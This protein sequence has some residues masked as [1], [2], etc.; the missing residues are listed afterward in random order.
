MAGIEVEDL[1]AVVYRNK[2]SDRMA[3]GNRVGVC[4]SYASDIKESM[5]LVASQIDITVPEI[6]VKMELSR[7]NFLQEVLISY[8]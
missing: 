2:V 4:Q 6:A 7:R 8:E 5:C 1:V 3:S